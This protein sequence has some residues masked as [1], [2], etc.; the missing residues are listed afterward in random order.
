MQQW[1]ITTF[2][3][4]PALTLLPASHHSHHHQH[5]TLPLMAKA[6]IKMEENKSEAKGDRKSNAREEEEGGGEEEE[7]RSR[8]KK[9]KKKKTKKKKKKK[10]GIKKNQKDE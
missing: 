7:G 9:K 8:R 5:S 10:K 1:T 4:P 2:L 3:A 6:E